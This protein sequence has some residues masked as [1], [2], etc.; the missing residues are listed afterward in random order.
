MGVGGWVSGHGW[1]GGG[2]HDGSSPCHPA[3]PPPSHHER[4]EYSPCD[5]S[6]STYHPSLFDPRLVQCGLDGGNGAAV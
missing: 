2:E 6:P 5:P 3:T 4:S 1:Q